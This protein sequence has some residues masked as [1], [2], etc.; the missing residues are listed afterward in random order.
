[1]RL[2]PPHATPELYI[3]MGCGRNH[4]SDAALQTLRFCTSASPPVILSHADEDHWCGAITKAMASAGYPA[5]TL[6]WTAPA[7]AGSAAFM[8]FARSV[9]TQG[10]SVRTLDLNGVP[11]NTVT[12]KTK[13]GSLLIAQG[14]SKQFNHSGLIV[15]AVR[16][17]NQ[18]YWLLPGDCDYHF[19][20]TTL[21]SMAST[22]CCVALS[23]FHHGARP[24]A[25]PTVPRA[26]SQEYRRLVYSFGCGNEHKHPTLGAVTMHHAAGWTHDAAWLAGP[27][28]ALPSAASLVRAT[29]WTPSTLPPYQHAGGVLIGWSAA[30]L[31]PPAAVCCAYGCAAA[32]ATQ[33]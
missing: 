33:V 18:H 5:H 16:P 2:D 24:N 14:T 12:A 29:A 4:V 22:S 17:D 26:V 28:V 3:D 8:A 7:T 6:A 13:T 10:G 32:I 27:G 21:K 9:W 25:M 19:F 15:A 11:P 23:A 20:P 30:P 1:V 31:I